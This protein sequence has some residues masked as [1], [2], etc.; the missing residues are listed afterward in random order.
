MSRKPQ[1][2]N[3]KPE[4]LPPEAYDRVPRVQ[5][6]FTQESVWITRFDR[7]GAP[8]ATYPV[9]L[10]DAASAFNAAGASTGLLAENTLFHQ[11]VR[12]MPRIGTWLPPAT[13]TLV[14]AGRRLETMAVP[15]P[16]FVFV[17][18]GARY[19][20][21]AATERPRESQ[22]P[23]Y[24][25][26]LPNVHSEHGGICAG[27]VPFPKAGAQTMATAAALFFESHF[28]DD[29]AQGKIRTPE[30]GRPI[31]A[32]GRIRPDDARLMT[33]NEEDLEPDEEDDGD[34]EAMREPARGGYRV[35][36]LRAFL[37]SLKRARV[38]PL[39]RLVRAGVTLQQLMEVK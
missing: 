37:R 1:A 2:A 35:G 15:L 32:R 29:L 36:E 11:N 8:T 21:F 18:E 19:W 25:A 22:V 3:R 24:L 5:L 13:R 34:G 14:F 20:I 28:N 30:R 17:G 27:T 16:G 26:P 9:A 33:A 38:F 4:K 31:A 12:G 23:L 6:T 7:R 39:D 10:G